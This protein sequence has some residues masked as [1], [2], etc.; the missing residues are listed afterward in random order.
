[1]YLV[2]R[3]SRAEKM[4]MNLRLKWICKLHEGFRQDEKNDKLATIHAMKANRGRWVKAALRLE[5]RWRPGVRLLSSAALLSRKE[6]AVPFPQV[7]RCASETVWTF[8]K[9]E[10]SSL[11]TGIRNPDRPAR[12]VDSLPTEP[13]RLQGDFKIQLKSVI[14]LEPR[15]LW[16]DGPAARLVYI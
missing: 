8:R 12:S 5:A 2:V 14:L 7:S 11:P 16:A 4:L 15:N 3:V 6:A 10:T 9:R 13:S 1:M